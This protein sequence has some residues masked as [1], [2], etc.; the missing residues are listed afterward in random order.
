VEKGAESIFDEYRDRFL[1][2]LLEYLG[3]AALKLSG[4]SPP[5]TTDHPGPGSKPMPGPE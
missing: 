2:D 4:E 5:L 1:V 3:K